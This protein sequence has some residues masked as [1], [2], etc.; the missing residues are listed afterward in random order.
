MGREVVHERMPDFSKGAEQAV[1]G[2]I[3][4]HP[5][6]IDEVSRLIR[7]ES[8]FMSAHQSIYRALLALTRKSEVIDIHGVC[9]VLSAEGDLANVGGPAYVAEVALSQSTGVKAAYYAKVVRQYSIKRHYCNLLTAA[10]RDAYDARAPI[11]ELVSET[12]V[13]LLSMERD[14]GA[15][16]EDVFTTPVLMSHAGSEIEDQ[17]MLPDGQEFN[18]IRTEFAELDLYI[19]G[20]R[21]GEMVIVG[22]RPAVGKSAFGLCLAYRAAARQRPAMFISL[23]MP[24]QQLARRLLALQ[25]EVPLGN[26]MRPKTLDSE[27]LGRLTGAA[28]DLMGIPLLIQDPQGGM[29]TDQIASSIRQQVRSHKVEMVVVDYLQIVRPAGRF[30][31]ANERITQI[32]NGLMWAARESNVALLVLC[33]LSRAVEQRTEKTPI[34]S[35]LR[36]SGSI[37]QD[38]NT[39][40]FLHR[41][42]QEIEAPGLTPVQVTVAK[43][44]N[45]PTGSLVLNYRGSLTRFE[46][47]P[48]KAA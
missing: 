42:Q 43:N 27:Q 38:A 15:T 35:D 34:L 2:S 33:Q 20:L 25:G 23:E 12:T 19:G 22:A 45:G 1:L 26:I 10:L 48:S 36:D 8:F 17:R 37:E 7:A 21:P 11:D 44:R 4:A 24:R 28:S 39:V 3:F 31:N 46:D 30:N 5:R 6:A 32:S 47:P 16:E 14:M 40:L 13:K 29:T 9:Q 18:G 41:T